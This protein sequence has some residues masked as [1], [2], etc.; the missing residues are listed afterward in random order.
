[1]WF[2][3][4]TGFS[5]AENITMEDVLVELRQ[6]G[7]KID[8]VGQEALATRKQLETLGTRM[9]GLESIME[10][11]QDKADQMEQRIIGLGNEMQMQRSLNENGFRDLSD[12]VEY[13]AGDVKTKIDDI[14]R[15]QGGLFH[16]L[17]SIIKKLGLKGNES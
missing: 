16:L 1:M 17:Q 6:Q 5:V 9:D 4:L 14:E 13:K 7:R 3:L 11:L 15:S 10:G 12:M 8:N 2:N